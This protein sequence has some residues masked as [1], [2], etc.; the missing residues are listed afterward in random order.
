MQLDSF[1]SE[2][3]GK[4]SLLY[5]LTKTSVPK[6]LS[7][8]D[9]LEQPFLRLKIAPQE[10]PALRLPN[11]SKPFTVFVHEKDNQALGM[12][13]QGHGHKHRPVAYYS[14]QIAPIAGAFPN[15]LKARVP[16]AKLVEPQQI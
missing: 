3:L 7:W 10:P 13:T 5:E 11:D 15:C 16:A 6:P 2:P 9:K 12:F 8:E 4:L 14:M 1:L